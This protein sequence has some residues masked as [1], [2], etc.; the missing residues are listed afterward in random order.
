MSRVLPP[1]PNLTQLAHQAK[2]LLKAHARGDAAVCGTLRGLRRFADAPDSA[3]LAADLKLHEAQ[4]ALALDYGFSSW[5]ALKQ[6]VAAGRAPAT[7]RLRREQGRVWIEGV[8]ELAYGRSGVTTYAGALEAALAATPHPYSYDDIMGYTGLAFRTR[9]FRR[10][11]SPGWCPS[12]VVGEMGPE[13]AKTE[14]ATGWR[15]EILERMAREEDPHMEE[16][17]EQ[18][19]AAIESG[20]PIV[21]YSNRRILDCAVAHGVERRPDGIHFLWQGYNDEQSGW[22]HATETGPLQLLLA[23]YE[24]PADRRVSLRRAFTEDWRQRAHSANNPAKGVEA[25]YRYGAYALETWAGDLTH[26][27]D[28]TEEE[29][30]SLFFVTWFAHSTLICARAAGARFLNKQARAA[31]GGLADALARAA[32]YCGKASAAVKE[33]Q[34]DGAFPL[35][36]GPDARAKWTPQARERAIAALHTIRELDAAAERELDRA[37]LAMEAKAGD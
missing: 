7:G 9:W 20:F 28:F 2:D 4:F 3:I 12:S 14:A 27:D 21:G 8:P 19:A 34:R 32:T 15:F 13:V 37:L 11:D 31:D 16:L 6:H 10:L 1:N 17:A 25:E 18:M 35:P 5:D 26:N 30:G 22:K 23:N 33:A 29:Q 36:F 24:A